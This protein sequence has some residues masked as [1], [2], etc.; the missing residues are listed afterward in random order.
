MNSRSKR[1]STSKKQ[2]AYS[3]RAEM[4]STLEAIHHGE[5]DFVVVAGSAGNRIFSLQSPE[6]IK[7]RDEFFS[8]ISHELRSP[9][10]VVHQFV[11]ILLDGLAGPISAEQREYL[12]IALRNVNQLKNMIAD[13][14]EASRAQTC[15][16]KVNQ[17]VISAV[18]V[19]RETISAFGAT[20][21][22]KT[23]TLQ[24]DIP[25]DLP[26]VYGDAGRICQVLTNLL[27]NAVKFSPPN[28][29]VRVQAGLA[30]DNPNFV[31]VSV[32]DN[33]CG[34]APEES[35]RI[36]ERLY[37]AKNPMEASRRGLG[38]GL[39]IC[40]EIIHQHGGR[41]WNHLERQDGCTM[42]FTVPVFSVG[43]LIAPLV[44]REKN[45]RG[46]FA[47]L[48][49]QLHN[50]TG[51]VSDQKREQA[52]AKI[53][54]VLS[55]CIIPDLDV[56]LP[57]QNNAGNSHFWIVART[58]KKGAKVIAKRIREQVSRCDQLKL[59][60]IACGVSI[61][62]LGLEKPDMEAPLDRRIER[63]AAQLEKRMKFAAA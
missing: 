56:I 31:C 2:R 16:L 46:R 14:L 32:S 41:I 27:D 55:G 12:Q 54:D 57:P 25:D 47:L 28:A 62:V 7:L 10:S 43:N 20:T 52:V 42:S 30:K 53:Q 23:I 9:L 13:L 60:N 38:L 19:L 63:L 61:E 36:F 29:I 34:V 51:W 4:E 45:S 6:E 5:V 17:S 37:Q 33:G 50:G 24:E 35:E 21:K 59:A 44:R 58:D 49:I 15:K 3:R 48:T 22:K 8:H 1:T 40:K 39:Y 18:A 26:P 11:S